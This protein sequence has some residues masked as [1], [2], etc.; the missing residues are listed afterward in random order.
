[1]ELILNC[2]EFLLDLCVFSQG[3]KMKLYKVK[4][5]GPVTHGTSG[6]SNDLFS[7]DYRDFFI[8]QACLT[9]I[10]PQV[11]RWGPP[12]SRKL[13]LHLHPL[14][15]RLSYQSNTKPVRRS[16]SN[17]CLALTRRHLVSICALS[18]HPSPSP[19]NVDKK[20]SSG[21]KMPPCLTGIVRRCIKVGG[22]FYSCGQSEET[23]R[24]PKAVESIFHHKGEPLTDGVEDPRSLHPV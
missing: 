6:N 4:S 9:C 1:M 3:V 12:Q 5:S 11:L 16:I 2:T 21:H 13:T 23:K 15:P 7:R 14:S 19:I 22:V 10:L 20:F 17:R 8:L 18:I 24:A